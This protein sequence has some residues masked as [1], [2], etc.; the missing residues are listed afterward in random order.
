MSKLIVIVLLLCMN[1]LAGVYS[2]PSDRRIIWSAGSDQWNNGKL[3]VYIGVNCPGLTEGNLSTDNATA[4]Q[5]CL[6]GLPV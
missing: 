5:N 1:V 4:I 6:N 3:P 2:L